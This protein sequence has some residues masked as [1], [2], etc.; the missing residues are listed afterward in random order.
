MFPLW[1]VAIAP[2][3]RAAGARR[4]V[5]IG[6]LRGET[7]AL[8]LDGLGPDAE[9]HV[10]DPVPEFDPAEHEQRV[11]GPLLFHRDAQ[12]QRAAR[13]SPAVDVALIDGDHNWYTVYHELRML[14]E[15]AAPGRRAAAGADHARRRLAVRPPR[16]LLRA[17]PDPRGVPPAVRAGRACGRARKQLLRQGRPQPDDVQRGARGRSAQRR[18]DRA[19]RLHRR[20]RPAAARARA[21]RSTSGSRSSSRRSG[22]RSSPSCAARSTGS[23]AAEGSRTLLEVAE[24]GSACQAMLFQHNDVL[25]ADA[26][27]RA[28]PRDRYLDLL[29]GRAARRALPRERAPPRVPRAAHRATA[30]RP[31]A[32]QLA[33]PGPRRSPKWTRELAAAGAAPG[34]SRRT[35]PR[36][37]IL[38]VHDDGPGAARPPA[39]VPRHDPRR[40]GAGRPRRVR[41]RP[42]RRRD[43]H[44]RLP[45]RRTR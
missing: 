18:D 28:A 13:R 23:R 2:V 25:R 40:R 35:R 21:A 33:R 42:R 15:S 22:S 16:P 14:A 32:D 39:S 30:S 19:R 4:V 27:A 6:A 5:E 37:S 1:E 34:R 31:S 8:M 38:P 20:V 45:R 7:T 17:R 11:P 9:L 26:T 36:R 24:D 41:H 44:A 3:L 43:L 10:I 29:E 12:P